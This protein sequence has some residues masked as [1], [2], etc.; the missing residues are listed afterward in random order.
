M[1][2]Q[3]ATRITH[4]TRV[5]NSFM[6]AAIIVFFSLI[7]GVAGYHYTANLSWIDS[8]LNASMILTGM[9]PVDRMPNDTAK[10]FSSLY[11]IF[12]GVVFLS[13]IALVLTPLMHRVFHRF[14]L[15]DN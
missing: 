9:G 1:K 13:S 6:A 3:L 15:E 2:K 10:I 12:G 8:F 11:A 5:R 7:A 4:I 14:S